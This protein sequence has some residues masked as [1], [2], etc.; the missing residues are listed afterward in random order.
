MIKSN[1]EQS[2]FEPQGGNTTARIKR[3]GKHFEILV[4]MEDALK[5][6]KGDLPSIIAETTKIFAD[7]KKGDVASTGDLENAFGTS[8]IDEI[9]NKI[10]KDGEIE[11]TQ[12]YRDEEREKKIKQVVD[13]L[14]RNAI[15]VRT[16]NPFTPEKIKTALNEARVNIKN[17]SVENQ[18][19][20]I[21]AQLS[22]LLPIKIE[23]KKV[24]VTIPAIYTGRAYGVVAQYKEKE[25]WLNNGS[26]Q[27]VVS[28]PAGLI[29][30]FYDKL[31]SITHGSALTEEI[32]EAQ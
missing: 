2:K 10:V 4:N 23:T 13:F 8:N 28:I 16:G 7:L 6:R 3:N 29:M 12:D 30:D 5:F 21:L 17:T 1:L 24:K 19:P 32:K 18:V 22:K 27:V 14:V 20:E 31:N 26:L 25:D 11:T 9:V 15:D